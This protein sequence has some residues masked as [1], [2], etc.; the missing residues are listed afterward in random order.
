MDIVSSKKPPFRLCTKPPNRVRREQFKLFGPHCLDSYKLGHA[1]QYT[2]GTEFIFSN[3]TARSSKYLNLPE[4]WD[5]NK[6]VQYGVSATLKEIVAIWDESFF[7]Q[8]L[9][10][11]LARY[12][13]RVPAFNGAE[14][15]E[16]VSVERLTALHNLGY[17]PIRV[18]AIKEGRRVNIGVPLFTVVNTHADFGWITNSLETHLSNESW[19]GIAVATVAHCY[20]Q[21]LEDYAEK[22]GAPKDFVQWQGHC[23][24]DRGMSG[25]MDAAK[26]CSPHSVSFYGTDSVSAF[27][28]LDFF[29]KGKETFL[30]GSVNATEHSVMCLDGEDLEFETI[31]RIISEVHDTGVVSFVA[32]SWDFWQ[33]ITDFM[34]RLRDVIVARKF[35]SIGLSKV[36]VRPDSGDPADI[37]CGTVKTIKSLDYAGMVDMFGIPPYEGEM[38]VEH[39]GKYY[40]LIPGDE[41][42]FIEFKPTPEQKGAIACLYEIFG[43]STTDKGYKMLWERVGLIYGD[44]ITLARAEDIL[45]RLMDKGFASSNVVL[46]IGSYTYQ[47]LTRDSIGAAMKATYGVV[48]GVG[49]EMVKNPKTDSGVKKSAKGLPMVTRDEKGDYH[50]QDQ[51]DWA[52]EEKGELQLILE[53][54]NFYNETSIAEIREELWP[55]AVAA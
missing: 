53:D 35:N 24:A 4:K 45:S 42:I 25:M 15:P 36:V 38:Q 41:P 17:L 30:G 27:D 31:K 13:L 55:T 11:C 26:N 34:P 28:F 43:G 22:T 18:K 23:F 19:K 5:D 46:G 51:T 37:I 52:G 9:E 21:I 7:T 3:F 2:P 6:V 44:S 49:H 16:D 14:K 32:D 54:G 12:Q 50:L 48:N 10:H 33:V 47:Y 40:T 29:Y 39:K 1:D 20:R 8:P